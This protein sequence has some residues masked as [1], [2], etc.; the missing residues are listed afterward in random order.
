MARTCVEL[1]PNKHVQ[2]NPNEFGDRANIGRTKKKANIDFWSNNL[3]KKVI[4][5]NLTVPK[6][7]NGY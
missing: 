3:L 6:S 2:I 5:N 7:K 1:T 4:T